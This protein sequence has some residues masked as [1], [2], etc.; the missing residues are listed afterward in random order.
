MT[1]LDANSSLAADD[2]GFMAEYAGDPVSGTALFPIM[3]ATDD[4]AAATELI[5]W[6]PKS[7]NS[8]IAAM[9]VL[10]RAATECSARAIWMLSPTDRQVRRSR[11]V[12]FEASELDNQRGFHKS[13]RDWFD[14]N[15]GQQNTQRHKD[16]LEHVRLFDK[17]VEMLQE[18]MQATPKESVPGSTEVV[19]AAAQWISEHPPAHDPE[20]YNDDFAHVATRFYRLGSGF[21]HAYKWAMDYVQN[22]DLETFK[23]AAEGL[24]IAVGTAE[25]AIALY[26]AQA[27]RLVMPTNRYR[28]YPVP[29]EPTVRALSPMYYA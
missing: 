16:F 1:P 3:N 10:C 17:R 29:L 6:R 27:Q 22:G 7:K 11:C 18:G 15:P 4:I 12:R 19:T 2:K 28:Y 24:A 9:L 5:Q 13:E 14:R 20:P 21:V 23:M 25:C 26:E 8:H